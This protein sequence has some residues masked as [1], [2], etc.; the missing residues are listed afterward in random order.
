MLPSH[1]CIISHET[2]ANCFRFNYSFVSILGKFWKVTV[3]L[4]V[5]IS[6][7]IKQDLLNDILPVRKLILKFLIFISFEYFLQISC[8]IAV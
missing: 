1:E 7:Y 4:I 5:I 3:V 2:I 8:R 6:L